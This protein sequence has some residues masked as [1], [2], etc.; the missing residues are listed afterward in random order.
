MSYQIQN[1]NASIIAK[2]L[3]LLLVE[4]GYTVTWD[5]RFPNLRPYIQPNAPYLRDDRTSSNEKRGYISF[6]KERIVGYI[7][8][9]EN[10][11][12]GTLHVSKANHE[13]PCQLQHINGFPVSVWTSELTETEAHKHAERILKDYEELPLLDENNSSP[14]YLKHNN[15]DA[16]YPSVEEALVVYLDVARQIL[17]ALEAKITDEELAHYLSAVRNLLD[18]VTKTNVSNHR[19]RPLILIE[20][21]IKKLQAELANVHRVN[22]ENLLNIVVGSLS[23]VR[24]VVQ[25]SD[26]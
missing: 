20:H 10:T 13:G 24:T 16:L 19:G 8:T 4:K 18:E 21:N 26:S 7:E 11:I 3:Y 23:D 5:P 14:S 1:L 22:E 17:D 2:Q 15:V 12:T 6:R 25:E 9:S